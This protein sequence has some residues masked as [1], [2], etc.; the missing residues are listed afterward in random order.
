MK[1]DILIVLKSGKV[2]DQY[3]V[4]NEDTALAQFD[5]IAEKL[6]SEDNYEYVCTAIDYGVKLEQVNNYLKHF[7]REIIWL[8]RVE[9]NKYI[10][11]LT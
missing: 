4:E 11:E 8:T 5:E 1:V 3:V 7:G 10:N 6:I 9:V 2:I